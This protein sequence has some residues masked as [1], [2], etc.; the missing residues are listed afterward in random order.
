MI[1]STAVLQGVRGPSSDEPDASEIVDDV[2]SHL[3]HPFFPYFCLLILVSL[4]YNSDSRISLTIA[5]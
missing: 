4:A 3:S 2:C 5:P 1:Q